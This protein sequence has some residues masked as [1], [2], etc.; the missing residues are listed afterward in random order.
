MKKRLKDTLKQCLLDLDGVLADFNLGW[1]RLNHLPNAYANPENH[2]IYDLTDIY[3]MSLDN[4]WK[5]LNKDFFA[6]LP[7]TQEADELVEF[8]IDTFGVQNITILSSPPHG[9]PCAMEGKVLGVNKH[10][11]MLKSF[12]F[13][14]RKRLCSGHGRVLIDDF[15]KHIKEFN[16]GGGH[17]ILV[18]RPWNSGFQQHTA[19]LEVV[20]ANVYHVF[21]Q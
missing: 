3:N 10:F 19:T 13:G 7:K 2:G 8:L 4:F 11:P 20:K 5:G 9:Y 16:A 12:L 21:N 18:P 14:S 17:G 6:E 1:H 15:D